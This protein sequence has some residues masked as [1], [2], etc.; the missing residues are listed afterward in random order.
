MDKR[1][2]SDD[3][4]MAPLKL[5]LGT[6]DYLVPLLANAH[7]REW[8]IKLD[9]SLGTIVRN[10]EPTATISNVM[11]SGLTGALIQ[12]PDK[13]AELVFAFANGWADPGSPGLAKPKL[14]T[15]VL[16]ESEI[17]AAAS[18]KQLAQAFR[19]MMEEA[20]PFLPQ[21]AMTRAAVLGS[22]AQKVS[23]TTLQ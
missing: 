20:Y 7:A 11:S 19:S 12:F 4:L 13:L 16:P 10:F 3:H 14:E 9:E 2:E 22:L 23:S 21:L 17:M 8:R 6:K 5:R 15:P 1:T 18:P